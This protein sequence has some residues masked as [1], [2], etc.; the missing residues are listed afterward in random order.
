MRRPKIMAKM[1]EKLAVKHLNEHVKDPELK[2]KLTPEYVMGCK[3]L[4]FSN[5]YYQALT[6]PSVDV[7]TT[8]IRE[9]RADS[10]VTTDGTVRPT[11]AIIFGT[12]FKATKR[13]AAHRIW[14]RGGVQLAEA[15]AEGQTAY[16]GTTVAGFPNLFLLLG[17][18]TTLAHSAMT[19]MSEAQIGYAGDFVGKLKRQGIGSAAVK[20]DVQAAYNEK[21]QAMAKGSVWNAGG[22]ESWYL[23]A[24]GNNTSI[25]PTFTWRFR[26]VTRRFDLDDYEVRAAVPS[27]PERPQLLSS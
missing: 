12:G 21:V 26:K 11:D 22:C 19:L 7:V 2:A 17:P 5:T 16:V 27:T 23:D 8:G 24:K 15:W 1:Q 4:L 13:P 20:P 10:I 6:R 14:G 9:I 18:N 3:R 25:W